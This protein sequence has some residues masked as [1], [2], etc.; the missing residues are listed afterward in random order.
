MFSFFNKKDGRKKYFKNLKNK[1]VELDASHLK[2]RQVDSWLDFLSKKEQV[3]LSTPA[4]S[5]FFTVSGF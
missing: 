1:V 2:N 3:Q 4:K 5:L